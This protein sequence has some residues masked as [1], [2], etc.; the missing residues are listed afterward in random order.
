MA[1]KK[2]SRDKMTPGQLLAQ[3]AG[4][5]P[6]PAQTTKHLVLDNKTVDSF[7]NLTAR[8]G[9]QQPGGNLMS[10]SYYNLGPFISR[11]RLE[12]E[13]MYR[14]SW[15]VG[16]VVDTVSED[17]T[18]E[19]ISMYSE[20]KPDDIGKL[21]VAISEFAIWADLCS[22]IKWSR[23]Y[24]GALAVILIDG[25][26]YSKELNIEAVRK[27]QFK[28]LVV[29]DRW[30]C[31]PNM[32]D[33]ITD[34]C[35]DMGKPKYYESLSGASTFPNAKI[36]YSRVI[37]F[38][39][40][41]LPY[42][43]KLFENLWGLSVVE[44]MLDR[45]IA[46]DS[47]TAGAAQLLYKA[48]LRVIGVKGFR[49]ALANGGRDEEAVIKQFQYIRALQ[50]NEGITTLD[51]EDTFNTH[52]YT[53]SGVS[54]ML[55]QFGQQ[56]SGAT[57]IPLVRL[58]GQSP[59]GLSATGE[60]DLRNYYDHINKEQENKIRPNLDKLF[61]VMAKSIL[62]F[63]LPEDFTFEFNP[64]WQL[65]ETE[66]GQISSVDV[67]AISAAYGGGLITKVCALKELKQQ[68]HI[69]GRFT[70][71]TTEDIKDAE[72]EPPPGMGLM[73]GDPGGDLP[74]IEGEDPNERL[75]GQNPEIPDESGHK[76]EVPKGT[77]DSKKIR[78]RDALKRLAK[79]WMD[80]DF[81]EEDHPRESDGKFGEKG[82]TT[83]PKKV[84]PTEITIEDLDENSQK[85]YQRISSL[86]NQ[87]NDIWKENNAAVGKD[88][89]AACLALI[90]RTGI[91]PG[92]DKDTHA[93]KKAYGATTLEGRHVIEEGGSVYLRYVGKKGVDL[94]IPVTDKTIAKML[95][96]RKKVAGD[97]GRIFA[98]S[99]DKLS[100]YSHSLDGGEFMTKDFRTYVGTSSAIEFVKKEAAPTS[101]KEYKKKVMLIAKQVAQRLGNTPVVALQAYIDPRVFSSW[102]TEVGNE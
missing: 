26:D 65:S 96:D 66:K 91:R 83:E 43:Q 41:E 36:H 64:L 30:M 87:F 88:E 44:R 95:L 84:S 28:G 18:R 53:F 100:E 24:G 97:A 6:T 59:A 94:N 35:K 33:L 49:E 89:K 5:K 38:D 72:N 70:N 98:T 20:M 45:L 74:D 69:T 46:F 73:P 75:G 71:I 76:E 68:S 102:R 17:M 2:Q 93:K 58:F 52:Q 32:G 61:A 15:L 29:L 67:N 90:M 11:N 37:R 8:L 9:I 78:F 25:A 12:L 14:S 86:Q 7:S 56:I 99:A 92:S 48:Y 16:Q 51:S 63:D 40:I 10:G 80:A 34:I 60:S 54:D 3:A 55:Q 4:A 62:G 47:A 77:K 23:L 50:S 22:T 85:K 19:G 39:G 21:Q 31:Q 27:D 57:G 81:K 79:K 101:F 13:A 42:Y 82:T 1:T